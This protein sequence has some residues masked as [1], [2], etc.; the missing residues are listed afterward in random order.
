MLKIISVDNFDREN[1]NDVLIC[2]NV[3]GHFGNV[4]VDF[5]NE[6]YSG[7]TAQRFFK[8]VEDDFKLYEFKG[9]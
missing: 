2:E 6:K 8:L 9:Y 1:Y 7:D 4:L 5:L 3:N